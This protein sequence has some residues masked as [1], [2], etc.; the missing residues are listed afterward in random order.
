[1]KRESTILGIMYIYRGRTLA[2]PL[3]DM[4]ASAVL[5]KA[6]PRSFKAIAI[7]KPAVSA[8]IGTVM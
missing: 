1:M 4:V 7:N 2:P 8:R 6:C 3:G 5:D